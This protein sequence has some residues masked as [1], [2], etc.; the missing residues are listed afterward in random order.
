MAVQAQG[1]GRQS[2]TK[3]QKIWAESKF[4][5]HRPYTTWVK[6]SK[7]IQNDQICA[8]K[9]Y[10]CKTNQFATKKQVKKKSL[11]INSE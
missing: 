9:Q 8:L 5:G 3:T 2:P 4:F 1:K 11:P 7:A 10:F 6:G